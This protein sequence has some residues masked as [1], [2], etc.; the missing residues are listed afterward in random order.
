MVFSNPCQT[1]NQPVGLFFLEG[2]LHDGFFLPM[3]APL[4][5]LPSTQ[6]MKAW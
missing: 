2:F 4:Q 5:I 6:C 3:L 1:F